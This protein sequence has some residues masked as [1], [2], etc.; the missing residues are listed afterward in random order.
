MSLKRILILLLLS[1]LNIMHGQQLLPFVENFT[2]S[3]YNGDNQ[4]WNVA[5]GTDKA[6]YFA[7][8]HYFLRYDGVKWEKYTMPNKTIIRSIYIWGNKIYC[9]SYKEFGYWERVNGKMKYTCISSEKLFTGFAGNEE[10]WKI[11]RQ[12]NRLFFQSFNALYVYDNKVVE[13]LNFPSQIS[14]CY[15]VKNQIYAATT[16]FGIYKLSGNQFSPVKQW[17][18]INGCVVHGMQEHGNN[19]YIF[20]KNKGIYVANEKGIAPWNHALNNIIKEEVVLSEHFVGK[21]FLAIGTSR[22]GLYLID[23]KSVV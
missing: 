14:Y 7:N 11:F 4:V 3:E 1:G 2:K 20:T 6:M 19:I 22:S 12:G 18:V 5:Q 10:I 21:N 13:R 9:G 8:N 17:G 16:R 23:R 15:V